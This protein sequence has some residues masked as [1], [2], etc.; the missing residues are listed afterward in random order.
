MEQGDDAKAVEAS[1]AENV[2]RLPMDEIDQYK[3]FAVLVKQGESVEEIASRFG[4][5]A[6]LVNQRLAIAS[7][8]PPILTAYRKDK[9]QATTLRLLTM[10]TKKQQRAWLELFNA[11]DNYAP[12]GYALKSWLFG[13]TS[14]PVE[15]ALFDVTEY[16]GNI[17]TDLFEE[18]RYFD[19]AEKF[20]PLQSKA[21]ADLKAQYL[22]D[23]WSDV[24]VLDIGE[25]FPAYEYVDTAKED[26]GKIY[27]V[28][29]RDG[30]VTPYEGQLSRKEIKSAKRQEP[31]DSAKPAKSEITKPLQNYLDLHRHSA[32]RSAL[33]NQQGLALR[34]ATAQLIAGSDLWAI[35]ADPQKAM[36]DATSDSLSDNK[37]ESFFACARHG[38]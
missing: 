33:L 34:V 5:T 12:E 35:H 14:I 20:W 29:S 23:G 38:A 16:D 26:T 24:V 8:I 27:I 17:I 4:T 19:D 36:K 32:V 7:L 10:A 1:L 13:G 28:I 9:I 21:I 30:E 3:A 22:Q 18:D 31:T 15:N 37:A 11:S 25:Y 6:R 2:A